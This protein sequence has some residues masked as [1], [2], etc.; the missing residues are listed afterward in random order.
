MLAT[1]KH[2]EQADD[3]TGGPD[4]AGF[5]G[6][7][8]LFGGL[9]PAVRTAIAA[10]MS[11]QSFSAG[12]TI[13]SRNEVGSSLYLVTQG[14]VRLSV[15]NSDGRELTFR[16]AEAGDILGEIAALDEGMR[17]ADAVAVTTVAAFALGGDRMAEI[18]DAYPAVVRSSLR[19]VCARLRETSTQLEEIALY[20]IERRVARFLVSALQIGGHDM[21][22]SDVPL[23]LKMNQ[24]EMALLLGA[25][26]PKVNVALAALVQSQAITRSG[27]S[28]VC[29]PAAL[30]AFAGMT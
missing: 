1:S 2:A 28:I 12:Q 3:M 9:E 20:P 11:S 24:T 25:S 16:I 8:A 15:V 26:R 13:F 6:R 5:L 17:T 27:D 22:G 19:F 30:L 29:H 14:R 4:I 7:T 10:A 18:M 23:D 21:T